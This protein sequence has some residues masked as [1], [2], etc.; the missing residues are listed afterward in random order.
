MGVKI[1]AVKNRGV[2]DYVDALKESTS[3]LGI[4]QVP[5]YV[6]RTFLCALAYT[7]TNSVFHIPNLWRLLYSYSV[8]M[9]VL[10]I[11]L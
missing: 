8:C 4:Y 6:F 11:L 5:L 10:V 3:T 7:N 2:Q 9:K 1:E